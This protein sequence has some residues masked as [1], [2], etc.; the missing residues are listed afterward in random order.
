MNLWIIIMKG[1]YL[2]IPIF[3]CGVLTLAIIIERLIYLKNS[4]IDSEKFI[5]EIEG[6]LKKRKIKEAIEKCASQNKP[7]PNIIKAG[8][9]KLDR[10][11]D[12]IKEA[13]D[14]SA[15]HQIPELEK[16]L[17]ILATI[18]VIAPLLGLLGTVT[19]M[20]KAFMVIEIKEGLVHPGDLARGIWE[21]LLTT[22]GGLVV[23][24]P[25][26]L[27]YNYFVSRVNNL[28]LDMEKS[29]TRLIDFI[30]LLKTEEE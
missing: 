2:M 6:L 16:Y 21:A 25:A 30:F 27:S 18:A 9:L 20:I 5:E 19:G 22:V 3:I 1:G 26:Y 14:D 11:R 28:I 8:L 15:N 17:V 29:A 24:I 13:I 12:E 4:Q 10:T 23:A 7:V